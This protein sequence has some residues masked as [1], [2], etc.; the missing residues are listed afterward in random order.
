[1][2]GFATVDAKT[3]EKG[4]AFRAD[5][6]VTVGDKLLFVKVLALPQNA[7]RLEALI[8]IDRWMKEDEPKLLADKGIHV[9]KAKQKKP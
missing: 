7:T 5:C 6:K 8:E 3:G 4:E 2:T 9:A 1:M